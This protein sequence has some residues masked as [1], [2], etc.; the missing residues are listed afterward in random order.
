MNVQQVF[1]LPIWF[2][3]KNCKGSETAEVFL[4]NRGVN[5]SCLGNA[6][7][8]L[9]VRSHRFCFIRYKLLRRLSMPQ[10]NNCYVFF[11]KTKEFTSRI[12]D[13]SV[14]SFPFIPNA[15]CFKAQKRVFTILI[16]AFNRNNKF[17]ALKNAAERW[18]I[19]FHQCSR[20]HMLE[21]SD[22]YLSKYADKVFICEESNKKPRKWS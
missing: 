13:S 6:H 9:D 8:L 16:D 15:F 21:S 10:I 20:L 5:M 14:W 1:S 12:F 11:A 17:C 4:N 22:V 18:S 2:F 3:T 7:S 19:Q